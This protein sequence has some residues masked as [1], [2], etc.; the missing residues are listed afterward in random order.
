[1][2]ASLFLAVFGMLVAGC[3]YG[4]GNGN[5]DGNGNCPDMTGTWEVIDHCEA[6]VIGTTAVVTQ[7]GC[8]ITSV[9]DGDA[10]FVGTVDS[11]GN[12]TITG[13]PGGGSMTC[14]GGMTGDTW[15]VDCTPG[16]CH[17]VTQKR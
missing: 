16:D 3:G 9:W 8:D 7:N 17:V 5:G 13:D 11:N 1:M 12:T 6:G 10:V 4:N 14:T 2:R 15:T